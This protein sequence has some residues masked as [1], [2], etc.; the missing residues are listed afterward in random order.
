MMQMVG[1]QGVAIG[2]IENISM[3]GPGGDIPLRVY[4]P[5]GAGSDALPALIFFHGGGFVIGDLES[6][7]GLCRILA[8]ESGARVIA[9]DYRRA[10]EHKYPAALD[11]ALAALNWIAANAAKLGVDAKRLAVGGE[12]AGG[13]LSAVLAQI[14]KEKGPRLAMQMLLFPVTQI[15]KET[16]SLHDFAEGYF[17]ERATLSWFYDCYLPKGADTSDPRISPLRAKDLSGVAPAYVMLG[18]YDPLHDEGLLY[19]EKLRAAGVPVTIADYPGMVHV[20]I[21]LQS[22]LPQA[23]QALNDAAHALKAAFKAG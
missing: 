12:S 10:P 4:T 13:A 17:L 22:F 14:A 7:D 8:N 15:G 3:P 21:Y 11:D 2:R 23:R 20:F 19:A 5:V 9:V 18:G 1:P 16:A 6:H